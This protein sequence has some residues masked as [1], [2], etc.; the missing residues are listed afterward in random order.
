[1]TAWKLIDLGGRERARMPSTW[2]PGDAHAIGWGLYVRKAL[3]L[4]DAILV[5]D[6]GRRRVLHAGLDS[7]LFPRPDD[8]GLHAQ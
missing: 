5:D 4:T 6:S 3:G 8:L 2:M 7:T 1:M